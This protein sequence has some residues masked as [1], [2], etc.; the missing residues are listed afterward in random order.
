MRNAKIRILTSTLQQ[1][2]SKSQQRLLEVLLREE[3]RKKSPLEICRLAGYKSRT[4]WEEALKDEQFIAEVEDLGVILRRYN[5]NRETHLEVRLATNIEEELERD[6]WDMRRLKHDYP[7][8]RPPSAYEVDFTWIANPLLREQ[9]KRYFRH[10]LPRWK[11]YT[12]QSTINHLK[13]VLRL[14]PAEVHMG[15]LERSHIEA[16]LPA[17]ERLS[18]YQ[19]NRSLREMKIMVEYMA[20]SPAWTGLRPPR[21]LIWEEDIPRR[22]ELLPRPIPPYVL[23][24]FDPLLAQAIQA[25]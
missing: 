12:F 21:F 13:P 10:R 25:M 5:R 24:Q 9:I 8:H 14:L 4:P 20:S 22:P 7:K 15:T 3:N 18:E 2:W 17:M 11:A 16:L 23:D 19:A 1:P 6:I